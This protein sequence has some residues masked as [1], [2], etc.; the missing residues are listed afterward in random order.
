MELKLINSGQNGNANFA[1]MAGIAI[2]RKHDQTSA[3]YN[4]PLESFP[5]SI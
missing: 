5:Y 2:I 3:N 4:N 1:V